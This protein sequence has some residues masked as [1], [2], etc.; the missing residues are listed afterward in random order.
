MHIFNAPKRTRFLTGA[1]LTDSQW[2]KII[3]NLKQ[4]FFLFHRHSNECTKPKCTIDIGLR[5]SLLIF[6]MLSFYRSVRLSK[7]GWVTFDV[8]S[9][10]QQWLL[11]SRSPTLNTDTLRASELTE[12]SPSRSRQYLEIWVE[13]TEMG[14]QATKPLETLNLY[15]P[16]VIGTLIKDRNLNCSTTNRSS[17]MGMD[18][19]QL[20]R[21]ALQLWI[22]SMTG[23]FCST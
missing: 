18:W 5:W 12:M 7:T 11:S 2:V 22:Y 20:A 16:G 13:S 9:A 15:S 4:R 19:N 8:T 21:K 6:S 10:V 1:T 23:R 14:R 17:F 3:K